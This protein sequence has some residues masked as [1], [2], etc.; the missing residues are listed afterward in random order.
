MPERS[1][2]GS[3]T[4]KTSKIVR[5]CRPFFIIFFDGLSVFLL[6]FLAKRT[7]ERGIFVVNLWSIDGKTVGH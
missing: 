6:G 4:M 3:R 2:L 5:Q 7:E 1:F